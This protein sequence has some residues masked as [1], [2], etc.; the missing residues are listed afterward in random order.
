MTMMFLAA[1]EMSPAGEVA[2]AFMIGWIVTTLIK[3]VLT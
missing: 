1:A 3:A 2:M